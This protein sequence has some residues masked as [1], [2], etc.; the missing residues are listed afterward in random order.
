MKITERAA[1]VLQEIRAER[2]LAEKVTENFSIGDGYDEDGSLIVSGGDYF[3][4]T[5]IGLSDTYENCRTD[6]RFV[7]AS[8]TLTPKLLHMMETA[9]EGLLPICELGGGRSEG[10][11]MA[12]HVLATIFTQ[13]EETK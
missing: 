3:G 13:W 12:E 11:F 1:K 7:A 10:N 2:A 9:I 6:C 4:D 8:R 5:L